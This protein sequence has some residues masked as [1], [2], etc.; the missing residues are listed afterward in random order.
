M[1][2]I[3]HMIADV[4]SM[5]DEELAIK[6]AIAYQNVEP[7]V[8]AFKDEKERFP[9]PKNAIA[10]NIKMVGGMKFATWLEPKKNME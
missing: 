3:R 5:S 1:S 10:F 6:L 8:Y 4:L 7:Q 9:I 2:Q